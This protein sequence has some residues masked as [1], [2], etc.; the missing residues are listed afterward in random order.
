MNCAFWNLRGAGKKGISTCITDIISDFNVDFIGLQETMKQRYTPA[1]FRRIDPNNLFFWKWIPSVGKSGGILC[2]ARYDSLGVQNVKMGDHMI[3]MNLWDNKKK[4]RWSVITV[5]GP[6]HEN[7]KSAFLAEMASFCNAVDGPYIIGGDFN[8][9]RHCG[10]KNKPVVLPHSSDLFNEVIHSLALREIHMKGGCYTWS[11][12]HSSPTLEKLDRVL[13]SPDW[14]DMF[15]LV[16]VQKVVKEQ[17]DHNVLILQS[18]ENMVSVRKWEFKFNNSWLKNPDFLPLIQSLWMQPVNS[19]DPIDVLNIKLKRVKKYLKGW[20]A[21]IFGNNKKRK[22]ELKEKLENLENLEEEVGLAPDEQELRTS[23]NIEL[24]KMYEEE[25]NYWYQRAHGRWLLEGD[26]NTS[27]FHKIANG[28]KR[29]NTVLCLK[30]GEDMVEGTKDLLDLATNYY[31]DLFGPAPGNLF[32]ISPGLWSPEERLNEEDNNNLSRE[33]TCEEVKN[34]LFSMDIN[35]APGPDNI[36]IEFYQHCWDI[37]KLDI[38]NLFNKFH[39]GSLDVQRLNYGVITLLPK[40]SDAETIQQFRPICLL[41]SIYKLITKTLTIRLEP[42]APKL[43][44]I[45]QNA[46]I[47]KRN[48]MDGIFSLHELMH[49]THVKKQVGIVLKLDFEKAYDKVNWDFL[50]NCHRVRGFSEKWCSWTKM[51]LYNGTVCVKMNNELGNYFQSAKGVRQGDP[52]SPTLFNMVAECLTKMVLSAQDNGLIT[53]FAADIIDKGVA[54]LQ[55]AD[56]TVLCIKHDPEQAVNLKLLLYLFELMSG[57]KINFM[58]SEIMSIGGDNDVLKFY[59]DLFGCQI[60]C[61][62][63]KYLGMPVTFASLKTADWSFLDMKLLKKLNAWVCEYASSGARLTLLD[64]CLSGIPTY[65]MS[66]HLLNKTCI[67]NLDKHRRRFLWAGKR[68]KRAYYMVKW[69]RVCRSKNKGGLGVKDLR[70][71][72]ISLMVKWWWKLETCDGLWQKIVRAKYLRNKSVASVRPRVTDSPGWKSLLKVKDVYLCGRKV[73]VRKGD[74][75]RFWYDPWYQETPLRMSH[76]DL[77]DISHAQEYTFGKAGDTN[78]D[79]PFRRSLSPVLFQHWTE[80]KN[81]A[82]EVVLDGETDVVSWSLNANGKFSTASVYQYLERNIAGPDNKLIWKAKL[83][84]KIKVFLWQLFQ[85]AVLTRE[86][87]SKR[88]WLGN[89]VCSFCNEVETAGHLFFSCASVKVVWGVLG[90]CLGTNSCPRNVWQSLVWFFKF[91]PNDKQFYSLLLAALVWAVWTIRNKITFDKY[92]MKSPEVLVYT[93]ASFMGYWAGLYEES[94]AARIRDGA[95][96]LM[97]KAAE[98]V[99]GIRGDG[100]VVNDVVAAPG[101]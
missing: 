40:M 42:Y 84:L 19:L 92:K 59:S 75:A 63:M 70:K 28:R 78:F 54:I 37:V 47:K 24:F 20:G 17:S 23:I 15:P 64:S 100:A 31:K 12:N 79:I 91:L 93:M 76:P 26:L 41:R 32:E 51:I 6:A 55:Y 89:P 61:L 86:N 67:K 53:G 62:P 10:E 52:M 73:T 94:E 60:G 88:R 1:F 66:M 4:C 80:I 18:G 48:I 49:H 7:M 85:D 34:A 35:K 2:G 101:H 33:F 71:Q 9:L 69:K 96:K 46:F 29:K 77:F 95:K 27:Y 8:I 82:R 3:L 21:N 97:L 36:P 44:S 22:K 65:Y 13:M 90:A 81:A 11:N 56:D 74:I 99:H 83:P 25:E 72:N 98:I 43:F 30:N 16:F 39:Q 5:Y 87:L 68:K 45:H 57:L 58:K 38:M 14:E 50:L